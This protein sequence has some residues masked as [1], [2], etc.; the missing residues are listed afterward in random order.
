MFYRRDRALAYAHRWAMKRNPDY[1]NFDGM[2]GDCTNFVSQC[3]YAGCGVMNYTEDYGWYFLSDED[4]AAAWYAVEYLY[5]F[6]TTNKQAG[7]YGR[8]CPIRE[9]RAGDIIQLS[10]NGTLFR[11]SMIIVAT[12]P[13]ILCAHH[14]GGNDADYRPYS[15]YVF[16]RSR[17]ISIEG[18]R[19]W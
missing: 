1:Y 2:G 11:H 7:P 18:V 12:E 17:A 10:Y 15:T 13:K 8:V 16:R 6:L 19:G 4:R 3:L 14:S 9:A 5:T